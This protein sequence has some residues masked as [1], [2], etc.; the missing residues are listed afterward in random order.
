MGSAFSSPSRLNMR[1]F[2]ALLSCIAAASASTLL[3][4]Q[5]SKFKADHAKVYS[6]PAEEALRLSIFAK[7]VA[8]INEQ[9]RAGQ[10][11][12][13]GINQFTDL[14]KE[15]FLST[16]A[17]GK[18]ASRAPRKPVNYDN[19]QAKI[20]DL[21]ESVDWRDQGVVT[22]VRNQ[23]ACGSC[24][25][26][27]SS[28]VLG[29]YAKINNMTHDLI[30]LSPQHLVSCV[31]NP[32][33]CG[34]TGGCMGSIEPLAYTYASLFGIVTEDDYPYASGS[35][36][37]SRPHSALSTPPL[38][39][40]AAVLMEA[41]SPL[42][43]AALVLLCPTTPTLSAPPSCSSHSFSDKY[44]RDRYTNKKTSTHTLSEPPSC[45]SH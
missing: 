11:W 14:T 42:R 38:L 27:A 26:F 43:C 5:W 1:V 34:G 39:T 20:A 4:A 8:K 2:L 28:S 35:G 40:A 31:P 7:N 45:S 33:K 29:S 12:K 25:A 23:G 19:L 32:L 24:W 16:Y 10:S 15:E 21:P 41:L 44:D 18:I 9:N 3:Q 6:S 37:N 30:E 17:S 13:S 36:G 22:M